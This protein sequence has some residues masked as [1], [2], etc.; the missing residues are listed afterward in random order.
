MLYYVSLAVF[1]LMFH[2]TFILP[3]RERISELEAF[4]RLQERV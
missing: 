1:C 2:R 4:K 3:L